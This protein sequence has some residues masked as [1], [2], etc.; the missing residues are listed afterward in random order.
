MAESQPD[1]GPPWWRRHSLVL[2]LSAHGLLVLLAYA[3]L[4]A[5]VLPG[6]IGP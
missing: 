5:T 4:A 3:V 6:W 1:G 2:V